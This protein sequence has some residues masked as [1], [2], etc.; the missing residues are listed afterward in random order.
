MSVKRSNLKPYWP[1]Y[2][3]L[4]RDLVHQLSL[5]KLAIAYIF[6]TLEQ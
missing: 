6:K 5:M 4:E 2:R 3:T 1:D